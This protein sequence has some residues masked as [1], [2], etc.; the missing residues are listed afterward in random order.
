MS[1]EL[2]RFIESDEA[3]RRTLNRKGK[4]DEIRNKVDNAI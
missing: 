2:E 3:I 4:V 1:S